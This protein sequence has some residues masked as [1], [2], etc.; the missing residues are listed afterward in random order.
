VSGAT[1]TTAAASRI[2]P[3]FA[4]ARAEGSALLMP[5]TPVGFPDLPTSE[6]VILNLVAGGADIIEIG[7]PFSD[8]LADGPTVQR[9]SQVALSHGV[10][11][12]DGLALVD[13]LR[14]IHGVTIPLLFMGYYNPIL[15]YGIEKFAAEATRVGLDG[16]IVPDLPVE[17]SDDLWTALR[18]HGRDLVFLVAPTSTDER[19][20]QIT[21]RAS[22][23]IYCVSLTGVTGSR[24]EL[25]DLRPYLSRIRER[26]DLPLAIGFGISTPDHV[27]QVAAVA[28]GAAVGSAVISA[29]EAVPP[30]EAPAA[31]RAFIE[32]LR[33]GIEQRTP[34][35]SAATTEQ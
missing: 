15:Q 34:A 7:I 32:S 26:T 14:S 24:S 4:A 5:Y 1:T 18:A 6:E 16:V 2:G 9:A 19:L 13:R 22:G 10:S 27:R 35:L 3:T 8:P 21:E 29:I 28:D 30:A 23:F 25:P 31:A 17:E 33:T 20:L 12:T 11:L